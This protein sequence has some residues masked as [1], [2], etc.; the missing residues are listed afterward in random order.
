[1]KALAELVAGCRDEIM[2]ATQTLQ[3]LQTRDQE[4]VIATALNTIMNL[5]TMPRPRKHY[6]WRVVGALVMAGLFGL[7][8]GWGAQHWVQHEVTGAL[9]ACAERPRP[10]LAP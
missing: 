9:A 5:L 7:A 1:M 8:V 6:W 10:A 3:R 4:P 2:Q